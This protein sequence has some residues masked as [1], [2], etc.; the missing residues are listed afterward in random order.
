LTRQGQAW[1][2]ETPETI[3]AAVRRMLKTTTRHDLDVT[4]AVLGKLA[5]ELEGSGESA[6]RGT[7]R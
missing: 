6:E 2:R 1:N 7:R 3:E 4:R 5:R